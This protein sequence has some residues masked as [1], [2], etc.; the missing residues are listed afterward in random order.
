MSETVDEVVR[1]LETSCA[2]LR[3][4]RAQAGTIVEIAERIAGSLASGGTLF[5][6]GNGGSAAECQHTA[7]EL[8]GRFQ[9]ER[10]GLRAVAL[11][12]DSSA[13]TALGNDYGFDLVF[14]RQLDALARPGDVLVGLS[15]SGA[16]RNV[17]AA[18]EKAKEKGVIT[19][20]LT[21]PKGGP[22]A[23]AADLRLLAPGDTTA[24]VQECHLAALH[25]LCGIIERKLA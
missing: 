10:R 19:V 24:V 5:L 3:A 11:T 8:T 4:L 9:L 2:A 16:S 23:D 18:F 13:L 14:A 7:A 20:A 25:I 17:V 21:G 12:T 1:L 6:C 15:T 22:A